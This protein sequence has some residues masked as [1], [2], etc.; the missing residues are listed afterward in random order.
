LTEDLLSAFFWVKA[1]G[2][3]FCLCSS[4][5]TYVSLADRWNSGNL[6]D[7]RYIWL[8]LTIN[9]ITVSVTCATSWKID[10]S[11]EVLSL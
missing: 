6:T 1:K 2:L 8:P 7:S 5:T 10:V 3:F 11:T 9:G 4:S